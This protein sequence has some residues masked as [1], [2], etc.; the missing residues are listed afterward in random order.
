MISRVSEQTRQVA[1]LR[2]PPVPGTV[3]GR[4]SS[5]TFSELD[6]AMAEIPF[7]ATQ[8]VCIANKRCCFCLIFWKQGQKTFIFLTSCKKQKLKSVKTEPKL[9][10]SPVSRGPGG[11]GP[12]AGVRGE[13]CWASPAHSWTSGQVLWGDCPDTVG[14][15]TD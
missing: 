14:N 12:G 3:R 4:F 2:Q 10:Q 13:G 9:Q 1:G 6:L 15:E 5:D 11:A 7:P 8:M